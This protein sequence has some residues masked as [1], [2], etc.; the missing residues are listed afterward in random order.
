MK[1]N[2]NEDTL[3]HFRFESMYVDEVEVEKQVR[4][5]VEI[6]C[7]LEEGESEED[8]VKDLMKKVYNHV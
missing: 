7:H 2:W 1:Y 8:L 3:D 5:F 6:D 4:E